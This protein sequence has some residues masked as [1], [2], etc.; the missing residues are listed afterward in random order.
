[1]HYTWEALFSGC[2]VFGAEKGKTA[3]L[4]TSCVILDEELFS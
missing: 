3:R 4:Q 2:W 1:M